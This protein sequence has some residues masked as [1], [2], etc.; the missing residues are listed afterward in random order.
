MFEIMENPQPVIPLIEAAIGNADGDF[1]IRALKVLEQVALK[2]T[3]SG[4]QTNPAFDA[5][6]RIS[7]LN[8][9][10]I[11]LRASTSSYNILLCRQYRAALRLERLN[12]KVIYL[13]NLDNE[14]Y[15]LADQLVIDEKWKGSRRELSQASL[16]FGLSKLELNHA[17]VDNELIAEFDA[18][19]TLTGIKLKK[20]SITDAGVAHLSQIGSLN[21]VEILYCRVGPGCFESLARIK[22]LS[23]LRLIGTDISPQH[24]SLLE[25]QLSATIDIRRGAFMGI[26]Y[27]PATPKC[28]LTSLVPG[29]GAEQAGLR[30]GDEIIEFNQNPIRQYG[31]LTVLL[32]DCA[33]GAE[34]KVKIKRRGEELLFDVVMGEWE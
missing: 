14:K 7:L 10:A 15:P 25:Q 2:Q 1:Q 27:N 24:A 20:C 12:A 21:E 5:I 8:N 11:S 29:S 28:T 23:S 32:R 17:Q 9:D 6:R 22:N 18:V 4:S 3:T 30:I 13:S 34:A 33:D 31:D 16:L 19:Y 26:R